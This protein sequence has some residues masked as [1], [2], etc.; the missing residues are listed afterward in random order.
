RTRDGLSTIDVLASAPGVKLAALF[1]PEHGIRGVLDASVPS[2]RD[3]KTGLPIYS[4]YG[5]TERPTAEMLSGLDAVVIDLQ[6]IGARVYT[7]MT[8]M[9]YVMEECAKRHI[10]V[11]VLDRPNPIGGDVEGPALDVS[12][13]G[14]TGYLPQ[15]PIRHGLTIGELARVFNGVHAIGAG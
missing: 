12:A 11:V 10:K 7:Y 3:D 1:S 15:M 6:D 2:T 13:I 4:L 5:A 9:G 14:F 8:T